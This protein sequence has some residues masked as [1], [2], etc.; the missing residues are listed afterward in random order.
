MQEIKLRFASG[1][2]VWTMYKGAVSGADIINKYTKLNVTVESTSSAPAVAQAV[3]D[4]VMDI[5]GPGEIGLLLDAF[6]GRGRYERPNKNLR[7]LMAL[8]IIDFTYITSPKTGIKTVY[9][10]KGKTVPRYTG[11]DWPFFDNV[12]EAY[13]LTAGVDYKQIPIAETNDAPDELIL[14]RIDAFP[15]GGASGLAPFQESVGEIVF[16]P[17]EKAMVLKAKAAHPDTMAGRLPFEFP[18]DFFPSL[19]ISSPVQGI[20]T[21]RVLFTTT[22]LPND[23]AYTIVKTLIEHDSEYLALFGYR[24]SQASFLPEFPF[25]IGAVQAFKEAGIWTDEMQKA[26]DE[27]ILK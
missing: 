3:Y 13:G 23:V 20:S 16:I 26:Q 27:L 17:L 9:D 12:L 18:A 7:A 4:G 10:L 1:P 2:T 8:G 21:P 5:G 11:T 14:G 6:W 24:G 15:N 25:H 19:K 22:D